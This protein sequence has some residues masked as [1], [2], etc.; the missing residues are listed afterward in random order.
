[1]AHIFPIVF[2]YWRA[3]FA[4]CC[5]P[6]DVLLLLLLVVISAQLDRFLSISDVITDDQ[7]SIPYRN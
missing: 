5:S 2:G 6:F 4:F 3:D 1:M 7:L